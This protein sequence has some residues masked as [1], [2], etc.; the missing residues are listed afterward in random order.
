M[1]DIINALLYDENRVLPVSSY[2][3]FNDVYYGFPTVI[4]KNGVVRRLELKLSEAENVKLQK[5]INALKEA[6]AEVK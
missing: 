3:D 2:D 1:T 4:G 6:I 5:S